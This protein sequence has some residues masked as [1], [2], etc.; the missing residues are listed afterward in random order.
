MKPIDNVRIPEGAVE[1]EKAREVFSSS[2]ALPDGNVK[3]VV[4]QEPLHY[5]KDGKLEQIDLNIEDTGSS[6]E[7]H[8]TF[9]DIIIP[10][11]R[12]AFSYESKEYGKSEVSL[13]TIG[14]ISIDN[15]A[16]N[17]NP[18]I[19]DNKIHWDNVLPGLDIYLRLN[20]VRVEFFKVLKNDTVPKKFEWEVV[21]DDEAAFSSDKRHTGRDNQNRELH[22]GLTK[23]VI[24]NKDGRTV[25]SVVEEFLDKTVVKLDRKTRIKELSEEVNYPITIDVPDI[26]ESVAAAA[27]DVYSAYVSSLS[28]FFNLNALYGGAGNPYS[29]GVIFSTLAVAEG[30]QIESASLITV[31]GAINSDPENTNVVIFGRDSDDAPAWHPTLNRPYFAPRT[32]AKH[33]VPSA[34][35]GTAGSVSHDVTSIVQEIINRGGWQFNN[36]MA[37]MFVDDVQTAGGYWVVTM[38]DQDPGQAPVLEIT[39]AVIGD[40]FGSALGVFG[41]GGKISG[42]S[43]VG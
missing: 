12:I 39:L 10:K 17:I 25:Y 1:L 43:F 30:A 26:T 38:F 31:R 27:D 40:N 5:F 14:D 37:F 24:T 3:L 22:L 34:D 35:L 8:K 36:N 6:F 33:I 29:F 2:F 11:E 18:Y 4:T 13:K 42:A 15:L 20:T 9:Y 23:S 32:T 21:E 19:S 16:L 28:Q 41:S 7:L